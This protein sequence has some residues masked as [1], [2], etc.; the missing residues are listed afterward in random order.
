MATHKLPSFGEVHRDTR[1]DGRDGVLETF[2]RADGAIASA[3]GRPG[4]SFIH[5]P[6]GAVL[7]AT[8]SAAKE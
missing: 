6:R 2:I 3:D 8:A 7:I 4:V 1:R 5:R